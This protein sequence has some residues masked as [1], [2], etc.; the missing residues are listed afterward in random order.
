MYIF[1]CLQDVYKQE[2]QVVIKFSETFW[3]I[4]QELM[5]A[6]YM[7]SPLTSQC[8][9]TNVISFLKDFLW[10]PGYFVFMMFLLLGILLA[11]ICFY[12]LIYH[13]WPLNVGIPPVQ[14]SYL[15]YSVCTHSLSDVI[16]F[17]KFKYHL[18]TFQIHISNSDLFSEL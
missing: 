5:V 8:L 12:G 18:Y 10:L 11:F 16:Q 17:L 2:I 4:T 13:S 15:F 6:R 9:P 7:I 3:K 14:F 1:F